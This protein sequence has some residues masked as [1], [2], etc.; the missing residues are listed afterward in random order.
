MMMKIKEHQEHN[1]K[2]YKL[3]KEKIDEGW[4]G[5][6][7]GCIE[8]FRCVYC[9]ALLKGNSSLI[10]YVECDGIKACEN[11]TCWECYQPLTK[12]NEKL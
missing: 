8:R 11:L 6:H 10:S 5:W 4:W 3:Y 9:G 12:L 2:L 1:V 7:I